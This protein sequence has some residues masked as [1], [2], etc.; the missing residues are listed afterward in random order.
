[1]KAKRG[2]FEADPRGG[3]R[4]GPCPGP[5]NQTRVSVALN[6]PIE[7]AEEVRF[8]VDDPRG[9]VTAARERF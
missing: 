7:G 4:R 9:F 5:E 8:S 2:R 6:R 3:G 1:M